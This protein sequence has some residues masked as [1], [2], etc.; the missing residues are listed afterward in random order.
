MKTLSTTD[1]QAMKVMRRTSPRDKMKK[2][3]K[4]YQQHVSHSEKAPPMST[5]EHGIQRE[6]TI[7]KR[8]YH[9]NLVRLFEVIDDPQQEKIYI[10]E[11]PDFYFDTSYGL[12]I[13]MRRR[14]CQ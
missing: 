9:P 2:L 7:M 5:T 3:R 12:A 8:C 13:L 6:I 11:Y 4:S 14:T 1:P 10:S